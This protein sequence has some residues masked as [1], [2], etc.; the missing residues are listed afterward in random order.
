MNIKTYLGFDVGTKRTGVAI[1]NSL[2]HI[3]NGIGVVENNKNGSINFVGFDTIINVHDVDLFVVGLPFN[4]DGKEQEMTF[5]AKS[6]G[7]KL[8]NR[9]KLE[10]VFIDEYLSSSIAKKQ[11]KYNHYHPNAKRG[12]V[13]KRSAAL[14]LQTWLEDN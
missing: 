12:D 5:I 11:L 2:T 1:A 10:T 9:Y 13:D 8:T 3:A 7:R 14:I 6:F 4:K